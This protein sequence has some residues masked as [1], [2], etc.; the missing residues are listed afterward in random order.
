MKKKVSLS[1]KAFIALIAGILCGLFFGDM[2]VYLKPFGDIFIKIMQITVLP[3]IIVSLLHGIGGL[4]KEEA[5]SI[6]IKGSFVLLSF[7]IISILIFSIMQLTFPVIKSAA[8]YSSSTHSVQ[9]T[10]FIDLFIPSNPFASLANNAIPAVVLFCVLF[11]IAFINIKSKEK[12]V[13]LK[14]MDLLCKSIERIT[15]MLINIMPYGVFALTANTAGTITSSHLAVLSIYIIGYVACTFFIVILVIP[16]IISSITRFTYYDILSE[17]KGLLIFAFATGN[18]FITLPLI[19]DTVKNLYAKNN[20][21]DEQVNAKVDL[22]V[23]IFY[24]F[25]KIGK[26]SLLF[27]ILFVA[28]FYNHPLTIVKQVELGIVGLFSLFGSK[29]Y[30]I[31]FLLKFSRLP[32]DAFNLFMA[33]QE[34]IRKFTSLLSA[35]GLFSCTLICTALYT[36]FFKLRIWKLYKSIILVSII[37]ILLLSSLRFFFSITLPD[38]YKGDK[39]LRGMV[40]PK[41]NTGQNYSDLISAKR[42]HKI[43]KHLLNTNA[44]ISD[45]KDVLSQIK[46]RKVLRVGYNS[47]TMPFNFLNNKGDLVGYDIQMAYELAIFMNCPKIEF[48]PIQYDSLAGILNNRICDIIMAT[49]TITS[50]RMSH[51]LFSSSYLTQTLSLVVEDYQQEEFSTVKNINKMKGLKMATLQG[52]AFIPIIQRIFPNTTIIEINN[53][54]TFF[55]TDIADAMIVTAEE[56]FTWTLLY[57]HY[58]VAMFTPNNSLKFPIAYP[59]AKDGGESFR[60][61]LNA[62]LTMSKTNGLL[63]RA[64]EYWILGEKEPSTIPKRWSVIR[65]VLHFVQ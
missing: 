29:Y 18:V 62:W 37:F 23:P 54:S 41:T 45:K 13:T 59:V 1:N 21:Q 4:K 64:Y 60:L 25:P 15:K 42:Y 27:F 7:W 12:I 3:Y 2:C 33:S 30:A 31:P 53:F 48:I 8:F 14:F 17:T 34:I 47:N 63:H 55:K 6:A 9:P 46:K 20:K 24:N 22:L 40:L 11:G 35:M 49:V 50:G 19:V 38:L 26:L 39:E 32:G 61:L 16:L 28:W 51:M 65:N 5:K 52:S 58:S 57:P 10:N 36:N 56:G 44:A 43:P